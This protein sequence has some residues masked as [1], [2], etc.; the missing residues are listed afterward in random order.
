VY[1]YIYTICSMYI[2]SIYVYSVCVD[3]I[4]MV[5]NFS[6][7]GKK[8]SFGELFYFL[9]QITQNCLKNIKKWLK[10]AIIW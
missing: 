1:R 2:V 8:F 10:L 7:Y 5:K 4:D 3:S 9:L 6:D